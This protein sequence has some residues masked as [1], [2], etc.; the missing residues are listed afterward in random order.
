MTMSPAPKIPTGILREGDVFSPSF[1]VNVGEFQGIM[2]IV[3]GLLSDCL[4]SI[5]G[6]RVND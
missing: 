3:I 6:L 1:Q 4:S 2:E 5:Q